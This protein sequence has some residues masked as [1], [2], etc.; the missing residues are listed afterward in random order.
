DVPARDDV[1]SRFA[2]GLE[3]LQNLI[4][5]LHVP[6]VVKLSG[7]V[8]GA[9]RRHR[10]AATLHLDLVEEGPIGNVIGRVE[11]APND[12][13]GLEVDEAIGTGA[14]RLQVG[15]RLARL[16]ALEGLEEVLGD[17]QSCRSAE[18][19]RPEG[20]RRLERELHR[21]A[22]ELVDPGDVPI[23]ADG[24]GGRAWSPK[25]EE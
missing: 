4:L 5:D 7:L 1:R 14:H 18:G 15:R 25:S 10:V 24:D 17:D 3:T 21:V 8:D 12:V 2:A 6:G 19:R 23:L 13:A 22:V 20:R 11:L 9:P 16:V